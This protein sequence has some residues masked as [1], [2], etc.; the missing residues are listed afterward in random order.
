MS[1]LA[2]A[3]LLAA[4]PVLSLLPAP[5]GP[6]APGK[7]APRVD[8]LG[9]PLPEGAL[10]RLGTRRL[11]HVGFPWA[12]AFSPDGKILASGGEDHALCLWDAASGKERRRLT[13][14]GH[15]ACAVAFS[16]DGKRVASSSGNERTIR[17]WDTATGKELHRWRTELAVYLLAFA[18]G[19]RLVSSEADGAIRFWDP[20]TG[21]QVGF[22]RGHREGVSSIVFV[23]GNK[24]V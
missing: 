3:V 1:R 16:P 15:A 12:L 8:S 14:H 19:G 7:Q 24:T 20:P 5:A 6:P 21:K 11:R 17:V 10:T 2:L 18:P 13:G 22:L 9:D 4:L 23:R